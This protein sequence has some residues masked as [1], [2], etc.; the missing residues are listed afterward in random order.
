[1]VSFPPDAHA[2]TPPKPGGS[3]E[4]RRMGTPSD[5][6]PPPPPPAADDSFGD[7]STP[8]PDA[9]SAAP[10]PGDGDG[11]LP[12]LL[13]D[14]S[15]QD[16]AALLESPALLQA[17]AHAPQTAHPT[18]A[19]S[20]AAL[21]Q[22]LAHNAQLAA[23]LDE[24]GARLARQRSATQAQLLAT[25]TLERQWRQKQAAMDHALAPFAPASLYHRLAQGVQEQAAICHA[26]EKSFLD[27]AAA[28][29]ER[30]V[31]DWVSRY[32]EA[33]VLFYLRQERKER[34][35]EGRVGG[36]R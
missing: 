24:A 25:H 4:A 35:D 7:V 1:M 12:G 36:W 32:C 19:A 6:P 33:K 13:Q 34:W 27:D 14:K 9:D 23:Q 28:A 31:A 20:H 5:V 22:A 2:A 30:D 17:L 16:L 8:F 15:T 29:S 3:R 26:L 18:L 21:A 10:D 11:W